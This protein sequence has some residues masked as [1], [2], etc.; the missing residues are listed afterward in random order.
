M[1]SVKF[2]TFIFNVIISSELI[3]TILCVLGIDLAQLNKTHL[4]E[5]VK[6]GGCETSDLVCD[7]LLKILNMCNMAVSH[8]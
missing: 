2:V 1:D 3:Y 7:E 5:S 8:T 4:D 6:H